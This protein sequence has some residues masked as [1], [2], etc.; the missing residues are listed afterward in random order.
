MSF[1]IQTYIPKLFRWISRSYCE[2][3][4]NSWTV[5]LLHIVSILC[6]PP[7][8]TKKKKL[9]P[10]LNVSDYRRYFDKI[11]FTRRDYPALN[12]QRL[13]RL[14]TRNLQIRIHEFFHVCYT[15]FLS[16]F[17]YISFYSL[18]SLFPFFFFLPWIARFRQFQAYFFG[19]GCEIDGISLSWTPWIAISLT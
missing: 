12:L 11:T 19:P 1:F 3:L 4:N 6:V 13:K 16:L 14:Q 8:P 2:V 18:F 7:N 17:S 15:P 9:L 10:L 5:F